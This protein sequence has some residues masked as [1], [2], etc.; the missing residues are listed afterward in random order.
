[1]APALLLTAA[2]A[3]ALVFVAGDDQ[4][5]SVVTWAF[6][7]NISGSAGDMLMMRK[8]MSYPRATWFEDTGEGFVAYG[9]AEGPRTT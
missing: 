6:V 1:M 9:P 5:A 4:L 7:L 8:V 3:A 2:L